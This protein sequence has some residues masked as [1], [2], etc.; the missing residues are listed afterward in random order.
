[1]RTVAAHVRRLAAVVAF[2][3]AITAALTAVAAG[4]ASA[5]W[6]GCSGDCVTVSY[7]PTQVCYT[8]HRY[9]WNQHETDCYPRP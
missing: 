2:T 4:R 3:L 5:H 7:T 6:F 1:M 8:F 9:W